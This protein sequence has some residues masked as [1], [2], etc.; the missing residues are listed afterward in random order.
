[1]DL[2]I[3]IKKKY[4]EQIIAGTKT[5]E[6]RLVSPYWVKKL[7]NRDYDNIIFQAGYLI[8]SQRHKIKYN[9]YEIKTIK[10]EFFGKDPV[11]VF[12][13]KCK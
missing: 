11:V 13:I 1:M 3:I 2:F 7:V 9:G 5:E 10:H 12:A 4:L 6:Y 8:T